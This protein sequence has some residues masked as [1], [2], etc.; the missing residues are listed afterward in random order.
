MMVDH[1]PHQAD[2]MAWR[3]RLV[4]ERINRGAWI[5]VGVLALLWVLAVLT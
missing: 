1:Y 3:E 4:S 5:G 2:N